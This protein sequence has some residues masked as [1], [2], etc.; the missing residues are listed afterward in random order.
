MATE[1]PENALLLS[2]AD[3]NEQ[4]Q[5]NMQIPEKQTLDDRDDKNEDGIRKPDT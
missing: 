2:P 3:G 4:G 1:N 5:Q